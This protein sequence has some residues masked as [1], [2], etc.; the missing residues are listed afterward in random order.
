M[1]PVTTSNQ[2]RT[3]G[4]VALQALHA[5]RA[6]RVLARLLLLLLGLTAVLLVVTPWQQNIPGTGRVI[7]YSPEERPQNVQTPI[8]GRIAQW[9]VVEGSPVKKGDPIV[10]LTDNDPSI[11]QR[12]AEERESLVRSITETERRMRAIEQRVAGLK[13]TQVTGVEAAD[14]RVRMARERVS[15]ADQALSAAKAAKYTADLNLER[16]RALEK[17]GLTSTRFVELAELEAATRVADVDRAVA[18]LNAAR[19]E[20]SS[21][22]QERL[23]TG[24]DAGTRIDEAWAA[25]ASAASDLAKARADLT[26]LDVR[27]A[28]Q[29]TQK[30]HAPVDG[31]VWRVVARQN[32]EYLK[33]G[34]T[35]V[36]IVPTTSRTVVELYLNGNDVPMVRQGRTVRLQFEGWPALQFSG[37]PSVAVGTF[38]G[39]VLLVDATD[40]GK[41]KFRVLVEPDPNDEPWPAAQYLRQGVRANGWVLLDV[42]SLGYELWRQFNGFP[43]VVAMEDPDGG[44][45]ADGNVVKVK[46]AK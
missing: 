23:R 11:M 24:A 32:G 22:D 18:A 7:A 14:L 15:A 2:W 20:Q 46:G 4:R 19:A 16:Q 42:V 27:V 31:T 45:D 12:L 6:S 33:A 10:D 13:D 29:A 28:R 26:R 39:R 5:P 36:V 41:G 44:K 17:K 8:D 25:H 43:P 38:G 3:E 40:D 9:Y 37:W 21:L 30:V 1:K 35:L 34:A